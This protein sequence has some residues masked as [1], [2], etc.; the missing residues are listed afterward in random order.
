MTGPIQ[1]FRRLALPAAVALSP[2]CASLPPPPD[3]PV[4]HAWTQPDVTALGRMARAAAPN[5]QLSGFRLLVSGE[6][7][8]AALMAL[9]DRAQRSLDLQYYLLHNDRSTRTL[10]RRVHAA[11]ERGVRVRVLLDDL[12]TAGADDA[13]LC[14]TAHPNIELRLFNPF[15]AGRFS[16]PTRVLASLT[17]VRRIN[18]RMHNKMFVADNAMAVTGGRNLGDAYFVQSASSNF[19]DLDVVAAGPVVRDLSASF[20]RFWNADL[21]YPVHALVT[22]QPD[23]AGP[24]SADRPPVAPQPSE[25]A[26]DAPPGPPPVRDPAAAPGRST[27]AQEL[28][29]GRLR[30]V[31]AAAAVLT[32]DPARISAEGTADRTEGITDDI[33]GFARAARR[34]VILISPYFV[35]GKRGVGIARELR[36]RGVRLRVLTNSLAS[37]DAPVV[38]IGYARYREDLLEAGVELHELRN[39][40][41]E[42]RSRLGSFG[43]SQASLH[44]KALVI[45]RRT[46][47][48]GS[49]NIDP[50]SARLNTE[51]GLV[52]RSPVLAAQVTQLFEDVASNSS[53]RVES[54]EDGRLRWVGGAPGVP[55]IE[56]A[57][58][59]AGIGLILFLM[60]LSPFAPEELL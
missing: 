34:E 1:A 35:P 19:V 29:D 18:Q 59:D 13:L 36:A 10:L 23:C 3:K 20:D 45:D 37:T 31:W 60:L 28:T 42:P 49:M 7:A 14:L 22:K 48:I 27:L 24:L 6:D 2:A 52:I 8:L 38:H 54:G 50:R 44:A 40:L 30:L 9:A 5:A 12:N 53:Y 57:E 17:D 43:S 26:P 39:Q 4:T 58:P 25:A 15:P 33:V 46:L 41:G 55:T 16:T 56:G 32:D 51:I 47:V 11:A 21:A